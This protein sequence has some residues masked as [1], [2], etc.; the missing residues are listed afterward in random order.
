MGMKRNYFIWAFLI[1]FLGSSLLL[2]FQA[3]PAL[4]APTVRVMPDGIIT[5][6]KDTAYAWAGNPLSVWGNVVWGVSTSGTYVW[7]FGDGSANATGPVTNARDIA[8]AH[9]YAIAGTYYATLTVTDGDGL[10]GLAQVRIDVLP[11]LTNQ[12]KINLAIELGLKYL[13]L[14]QQGSGG[15]AGEPAPSALSVLAFENHGHQPIS[16]DTDIYKSTVVNGL[17][18]LFT[19]LIYRPA[20]SYTYPGAPYN[21]NPDVN[22]DGA[23]V[24]QYNPS[25][26]DESFYPHGMIMM[27]IAASGAYDKNYPKND[28]VHNPALNLMVPNSSAYGNIAG[29]TYYKVLDNMMEFAAWAQVDPQYGF[30]RGGWRYCPSNSSTGCTDADNSVGQWPVIGLEAAELWGIV[31]PAWVKTELKNYWLVNSYDSTYKGWGYQSG[32]INDAHS[33]AG[34]NMMAYVGIPKTDPWYQDAL[35]ALAAHWQGNYYY[36]WDNGYWPPWPSHFGL[37]IYGIE[38]RN[39]YTMYGIAKALRIARDASGNY[40]EITLVGTHDWYAEYSTFLLGIQS[41]DGSWPGWEYWATEVATPFAILILEPTVA[42]LRPV[43]AVTAFPN[44]VNAGT[45]VYFDI[46]GS[47]H[48][49]PTKFLVSWKM[50]FDTS[51]GA[52]W[53]N[54]D[55]QGN[56]PVL[57]PIPKAGGYPQKSPPTNYDV[58]ALLQVTDN[59]GDTAEASVVV[60]I[61]TGLVNPVAN[62]GGPYFGSVG[63][64]LTLDGSLSYDPNAGGSIVQYEWDL[65]GNGTYETNAGPSPTIQHTWNTPYTGKV[66]LRVTDNFGLTSMASAYASITVAD[67]KPVTYPLISYR[68]ILRTVWEYTYKFVIKNQ[69]NGNATSVSASLNNWPSQVIVIDGDVTFPDVAAGSQATSIDTFTIRIDRSVAVQ[70]SDLTW[71][72]TYTDASGT[73]WVLV[74]FP[75]Y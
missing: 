74:N 41:A 1:C 26:G 27:A 14:T 50:I 18:Y 33:G 53:A 48:Q 29:W 28:T 3:A 5:P 17:N 20:S 34:L 46:S 71:K 60:H 7:N 8:V 39:Y 6:T 12:A 15:W 9:T 45:T 22:G 51:F 43:A 30:F 70:N 61:T 31:A 36:T 21:Y 35:N 73:T 2:N 59:T 25:C 44:P 58:T 11:A 72:L 55:A 13:Y 10:S 66:G 23:I 63:V 75:L 32:Y 64:P 69:G 38:M 49:D 54:P 37:D 19:T 56:F 68:R 62:P 47:T 52:T 16:S 67:L 57:G 42:S 4:A 65:D 24:G 40:S